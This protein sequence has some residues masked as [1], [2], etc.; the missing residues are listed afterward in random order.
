MPVNVV[1]GHAPGSAVRDGCVAGKPLDEGISEAVADREPVAD[2]GGID[3]AIIKGHDD[4][5]FLRLCAVD[6]HN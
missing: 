3:G 1:S 2:V 6:L 4:S 5:E